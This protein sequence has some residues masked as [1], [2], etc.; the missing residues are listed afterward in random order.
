VNAE[1]I[2][3]G[4]ELLLG[5]ILDTNSLYLSKKLSEIGVNLYYK[6][7]VGDN[8]SRIKE[9]ISIASMR[10]DLIIIT[11]GLGPTVDDVTRDAIAE[12]TGKK[13]VFDNNILLKI[14]HFFTTRNI[15][16]PEN[17][18]LQAYIP[19]GA[20]I[21][22]NKIGTAPGFILLFN[23]KIIVCVPGVP[24]EMKSMIETGVIPYLIENF[25][26]GKFVIYSKRIKLTGLPES[27]IDEKIRDIF[28]ESR[29]PT[30]AILA[31][32]TEI[33]I[34]LTSKAENKEKAI[35]LINDVKKIIYERLG[36]NIYGEDEETIEEK[37]SCVLKEKKLTISTAESCT[38][39]LLAYRLTNIPGSSLYFLGGVNVYS[40]DSK[41]NVLGVKEEIIKKYGAVSEECAID[42]AL[43]CRKKFNTD[44]AMAITGIAGPDGGTANKPVGLVYIAINIKDDVKV[45][46]FNFSGQRDIVRARAAQMGLFELY[47][48]I[49]NK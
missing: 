42:M 43:N 38:S 9:T 34:R 26:A 23:S 20:L 45:F 11:G 1:I 7:S 3:I 25:G 15:K 29:N 31:H 8:I 49:K 24:N 10:S 35:D 37:V 46:K 32:Q 6:T 27:Y 5:Q 14:E 13:L 21:L 2:T 40:N 44:I 18:K 28:V 41:I 39:G 48:I 33:E 16:M 12:F 17:N 30:V 22:E 19:E 47:R 4:T 36:E